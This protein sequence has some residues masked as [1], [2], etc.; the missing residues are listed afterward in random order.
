[1]LKYA[2]LVTAATLS[3][4]V[5]APASAE[6]ITYT[7]PGP[8]QPDENVLFDV[9][10][11]LTTTVLG[12]TNNTNSLVQFSSNVL[13]DV[14]GSSGAARISAVTGSLDLLTISLL[15]PNLSFTEFEFNLFNSAVGTTMVTFNFSD[16]DPVT[17]AVGAS[18]QNFFGFRTTEDTR[19]TSIMFNS[20]GAGFSDVRQVRIGGIAS[21]IAA[22]PEPGTWAMM[23]F[24]FG[25]IGFAMRRRKSAE[26]G[27]R[28]RLA[29]S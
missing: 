10:Q 26:K 19:L 2:V 8:V 29:Y 4:L 15:D 21:S 17:R 12:S 13:L 20:N 3:V 7:S 1:M 6:V 14:T 5:A 18:G 11:P 22:V 24:G 16:G 28:V 25:A 23:L 27:Q 9:D